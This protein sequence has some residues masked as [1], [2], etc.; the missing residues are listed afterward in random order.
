MQRFHIA[1]RPLSAM[2][3]LAIQL[4]WAARRRDL[5]TLQ[6][7]DPSGSFGVPAAPALRIVMVGDST[8][9]SPGVE[10]LDA[11]WPR[12][13]ANALTESWHVEL[14][15]VAV[16]GSKAK[17]V[18]TDQVHRAITLEP[19]ICIVSVGGND[20]LRGTPLVQF[21]RDYDEVLSLLSGHIHHIAVSGVGDLGSIPRIPSLAQAIA[22]V[23]ARAF[24]GS[25]RRVVS[26]Y[27]RVVKTDTWAPGWGEFNTNPEAIFGADQFHASAYGHGVYAAAMMPAVEELLA[28]IEH[29]AQ[30]ELG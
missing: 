21:E 12:R 20:A 5:P 25:I 18:L 17:D 1:K 26:R 9:T 27:P 23:R 30:S 8:V 19:D 7:Q 29:D 22:R 15:C 10:P 6:N 14:Y 2:A 16:G 28:R 4:A 3:V 24:D 11:T 13:L